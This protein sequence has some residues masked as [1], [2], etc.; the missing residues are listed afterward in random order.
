LCRI[1][2]AEFHIGIG[3]GDKLELSVFEN[4]DLGTMLSMIIGVGVIYRRLVRME[5]FVK[6]RDALIAEKLSNIKESV[7]DIEANCR[8]GVMCHFI[9][10]TAQPGGRRYYDTGTKMIP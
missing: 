3:L 10:S 4:L 6:G 1:F 2:S 8:S 9:R 5:E 7:L